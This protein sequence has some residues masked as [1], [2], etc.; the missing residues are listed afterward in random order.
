MNITNMFIKLK[1]N[2]EERNKKH[3]RNLMLFIKM[4]KIMPVDKMTA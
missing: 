4:K 1:Q 3:K 2:I